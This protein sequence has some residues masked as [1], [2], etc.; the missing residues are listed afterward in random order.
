MKTIILDEILRA[1]K[2]LSKKE[3]MQLRAV[4]SVYSERVSLRHLRDVVADDPQNFGND[5]KAIFQSG[6]L[7]EN[8]YTIYCLPEVIEY[9]S[10]RPLDENVANGIIARLTEKTTSPKD[11]KKAQPFFSMV[12]SVIR[13]VLAFPDRIDYMK[14]AQLLYNYTF[15]Y[16][17]FAHEEQSIAASK[18]LLIMRG[19]EMAKSHL[20]TKSLSY[21]TLCACQAFVYQAG[22]W[23][24]ESRRLIDEALTIVS[25]HD[26]QANILSYVHMVSAFWYENYGQNGE[27]IASAYRSW[28]TSQDETLK[29][30]AAL[31]IAYQLALS[32]AYDAS[33]KWIEKSK[34]DN[35][36]IAQHHTLSIMMDMTMALIH[37]QDETET[38]TEE[39]LRR[40]ECKIDAL[41][42]NAPIKATLY[43]LKSLHVADMG[44]YREEGTYYRM[45][46]DVLARQ[47]LSSDGAIYI[48]A[49]A[50]LIR[51]TAM[52]AFKGAS[53]LAADQLDSIESA[54]P[55]Y[56]LS[57]KSAVCLAYV[58]YYR[59]AN[60]DCS[61]EAAYDLG[62][63][64]AREMLPSAQ[65]LDVLKI[66]LEGDDIPDSVS[67]KEGVWQFQ[68]QNLL[69]M[70]AFK[71]PYTCIREE[72]NMLKAQ[73][74]SKRQKLEIIDA[75][76]LDR[77]QALEVWHECI[78][79][80][81]IHD[82]FDVCLL[83]ARE[84][85]SL[86]FIWDASSFYELCQRTWGFKKQT[87]L[88]KI[89]TLL[90]I[91]LHYEKC[92]ERDK[93][94]ELWNYLEIQAV[95]T[96]KIADVYQGR[97]TSSY[98]HQSYEEAAKYYIKAIEV[99]E[100]EDALVDERLSSLF[101][102]LCNCFILFRQYDKALQA[103]LAA[104][105]NY[106]L[107]DYDSFILHYTHCFLLIALNDCKQARELLSVIRTRAITEEEKE[108]I[109]DLYYFLRMDSWEREELFNQRNIDSSAGG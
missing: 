51:L 47:Y 5:M 12:T 50:E 16:E 48:N 29:A 23:Y 53:L 20:D 28:E 79:N 56:S 37:T 49:A 30:Y 32:K 105:N 81:N 94:W 103:N 109:A 108:R 8:N 39:Y 77:E 69:N 61:A 21:A 64:Q 38:T 9:L 54:A 19:L 76:F 68:Y 87:R 99:Y 72:I 22:F 24:D 31:Y 14:F 92:G 80:A 59:A 57:V 65:A 15:F 7:L 44:L 86:G 73:Y 2:T 74:P 27:G 42:A 89:D 90:E 75:S 70:I 4:V 58:I 33:R 11:L 40:A 13:Y 63:E 41:N 46:A 26:N 88:Q 1:L 82:R 62:L 55:I 35:M 78:E 18:D 95:G 34:I 83:C 60:L 85:A 25:M 84:A 71:M 52:G 36:N 101:T 106:P 66:V 91:A 17:I 104:R 102:Y 43:Y 10:D 3:Q 93:A 98:D 45:Y 67:G 100:P 96:A 97:A 6:L 107:D